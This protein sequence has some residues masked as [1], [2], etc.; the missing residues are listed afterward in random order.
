MASHLASL[1]NRGLE[2]LPQSNSRQH[3]P[4]LTRSLKMANPFFFFFLTEIHYYFNSTFL[5]ASILS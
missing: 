5:R 4:S 2:Q 1:L 3:W